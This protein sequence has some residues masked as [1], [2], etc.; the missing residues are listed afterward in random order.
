MVF[1]NAGNRL[2]LWSILSNVVAGRDRISDTMSEI[3]SRSVTC[4]R[5]EEIDLEDLQTEGERNDDEN[6]DND[7][8]GG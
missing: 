6:D 1:H 2:A 8:V 7:S 4:E 5:A 3:L